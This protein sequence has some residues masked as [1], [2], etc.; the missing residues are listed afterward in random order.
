M[1]SDKTVTSKTIP[2][3]EAAIADLTTYIHTDG[4]QFQAFAEGIAD[5]QRMGDMV[6]DFIGNLSLM[7][8][9]QSRSDFSRKVETH[10]A[11]AVGA[12]IG[13]YILRRETE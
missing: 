3:P 1:T 2:N 6:G 5:G 8:I 10:D 4:F 11:W 12:A 13:S 9:Q 7:D